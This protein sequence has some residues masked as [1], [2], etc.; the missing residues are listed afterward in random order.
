MKYFELD[1]NEQRLLKDFESGSLKR[2]KNMKRESLRYRQSAR[3]TLNKT[4]SI[5]I[6]VSDRDLQKIRVLAVARG[7]PYQTLISALL[8]QYSTRDSS[9]RDRELA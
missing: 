2:V 4:R 9:A 6:R 8:H 7:L 1:K 3:A 5:N